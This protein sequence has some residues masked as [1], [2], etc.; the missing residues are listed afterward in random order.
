MRTMRLVLEQKQTQNLVM[1]TELR[2]AISILQY[3][4]Y[5]LYQFVKEQA[6]ENPLIDL[7]ENYSESFNQPK[8]AAGKAGT[9]QKSDWIERVAAKEQ[10]LPEYLLD[11]T[12]WL[13]LSQLE[14]KILNYMIWNLDERG[15]LS[16]TIEE[17]INN[18]NVDEALVERCLGYLQN[19]EPVG[20]GARNLKEC[21]Q[22]QINHYYPEKKLVKTIASDYLELLA[23][24][25]WNEI[26]KT[27][28][29]S[30]KEV[31]K[32]FEFIQTLSPTPQLPEHIGKTDYVIPDVI[33]EMEG[34]RFSIHLNDDYIP[35]INL[36]EHYSTMLQSN[37]ETS[38]YYEDHFHKYKW[39]VNSI[40]Q[41]RLTIV[42]ITETIIKKQ[43]EFFRNGFEA[44]KP[45][46]LKDIAVEINMH[47]STVSRATMNKI[48]Q[49]PQGTFDFRK[50][51]STKMKKQSGE[52]VSQTQIKM[53]LKDIIKQ[54]DKC[55]PLSDQK[56]SN[57]LKQEKKIKI[58][59]RTVAKYREELNIPTSRQ[60]KLI[61]V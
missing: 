31:Q 16:I 38:K 11:Q 40:E 33:V 3:S 35:V 23:H 48:I 8:N 26:S 43:Q 30:L 7:K 6:Q 44:L 1:T 9:E 61:K 50:L 5:D 21:L 2:Q 49:T 4:T 59:R 10:S 37:K 54:E 25:K 46:T 13:T 41:R 18:L 39:L 19:L 20:I 17:I 22:I 51:F 29:I 24:K 15:Y 58:S 52:N 53:L 28:D 42:K 45:L 47:E 56:I 36:N 55:K 60:R 32:A 12:K 27:L 57:Y 34:D 14:R